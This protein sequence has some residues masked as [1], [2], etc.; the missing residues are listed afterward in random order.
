VIRS[1]RASDG[2]AVV[3]IWRR[4]V[5]ATHDFLTAQDRAAID[6]DVARDLP[7]APLWLAIDDRGYA[8]GFM[9]LS[10]SHLD[11]L[12]IDP[13]H[14]RQGVGRKLVAHAQS[15]HPVLETEVNEQNH[16]ARAFYARIGFKPFA[17]TPIDEQGRAYPLLYLR[18]DSQDSAKD[19]EDATNKMTSAP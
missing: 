15:F 13:R 7:Q 17:W 4:A 8:I 1:S 12:F 2:P 5:D 16:G 9:G 18:R 19:R 6:L 10:G 14:H 3:E 11:C